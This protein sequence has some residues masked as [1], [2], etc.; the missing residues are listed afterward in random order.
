MGVRTLFCV[1]AVLL[2]TT[3]C[4]Q[5]SRLDQAAQLLEQQS[6]RGKGEF[7]TY[8]TGAASAYRW[9]EA[10]QG[11]YCPPANAELDGRGYAKLALQEYRRSRSE[12]VGLSGYPLEVLSLALLRGLRQQYPC[13]RTSG[14]EA[15]LR[16]E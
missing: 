15:A 1:A 8:L 16:A 6:R 13:D 10:A 12:Y 14:V 3:V 2:S 4:A 11:S 9:S 5:S 7:I